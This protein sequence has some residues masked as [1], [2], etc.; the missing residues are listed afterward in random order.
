[1]T[2]I[3]DLVMAIYREAGFQVYCWG[4]GRSDLNDW[5]GGKDGDLTYVRA[6]YQLKEA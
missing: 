4:R 1:M 5:T 6:A 2:T 3:M